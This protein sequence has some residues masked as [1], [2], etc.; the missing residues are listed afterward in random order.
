MAVLSK[1]H[2][3]LLSRLKLKSRLTNN[4]NSMGDSG[5]SFQNSELDSKKIHAL[6]NSNQNFTVYFS[7]SS[8]RP[9]R[10][11]SASSVLAQSRSE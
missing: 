2:K 5:F 9:K 6:S 7:W 4:R 10:A 11:H 1:S 3:N 8:G